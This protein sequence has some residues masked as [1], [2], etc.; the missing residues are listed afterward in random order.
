MIGSRLRRRVWTVGRVGCGLGKRWI[1][2]PKRPID[3]V[4]RDMQETEPL[5]FVRLQF[6]PISARLFQ[7]SESPIDIGRDEIL[8]SANRSVDVALSRKMNDGPRLMR[9]QQLTNQSA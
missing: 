4:G 3:F 8:R 9:F 6:I 7:Q 1:V 5:F 2:R